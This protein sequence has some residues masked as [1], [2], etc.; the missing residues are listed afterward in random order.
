ME[1]VSFVV[2]EDFG[3]MPSCTPFTLARLAQFVNDSQDNDAKRSERLLPLMPRLIGAGRNVDF[4]QHLSQW[5]YQ[6]GVESTAEAEVYNSST[7]ERVVR[8]GPYHEYLR[9]IAG[10]SVLAAFVTGNR[11]TDQDYYEQA[12]VDLLIEALDLYDEFLGRET[13]AL[14][15]G[16]TAEVHRLAA[17][18]GG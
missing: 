12:Q 14:T 4:D 9:D 18:I 8:G 11:W 5:L 17:L 16:Q 13:P 15:E 3:D 2:G 6:K 10:V 7:G 1:Y